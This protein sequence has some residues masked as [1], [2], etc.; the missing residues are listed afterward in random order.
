MPNLISELE[1]QAIKASIDQDWELAIKINKKILDQDEKNILALNRI[2]IAYTKLQQYKEAEFFFKKAKS[3]DPKDPITLKNLKKLKNKTFNNIYHKIDFIEEPGK[4][5]I[6]NLCRLATK[7]TLE[8]ISIG[9]QC[10]LRPKNRFISILV[11]NKYIGSLPE[12]ISLRLAKLIQDGNKYE[13]FIQN[14]DGKNC[15]VFIKEIYISNKNKN[16]TSFIIT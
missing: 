16:K 7:D 15:T 10:T 11:D 1:K 14:C 5:K 2:G 12:D 8:K 6:I 4:A 3:I 9:A 13:C